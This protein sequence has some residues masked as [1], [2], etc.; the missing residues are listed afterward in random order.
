MSCLGL[1]SLAGVDWLRSGVGNPWFDKKQE[2]EGV[3]IMERFRKY[4]LPVAAAAMLAVVLTLAAPRAVHA[5]TAAL[6][7]VTNTAD[8]PAVTQSI[9]QLTSQNVYLVT[10]AGAVPGGFDSSIQD[11]PNGTLASKPF[12]VPAGQ[13]LVVTTIEVFPAGTNQ[14]TYLLVL[15]DGASGRK[16]LRVPAVYS[17][18]FQYPSGIVFAAGKSVQLFND[19]SSPGVVAISVHG[20][21]TSN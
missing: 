9:N 7:N 3:Q 15:S 8:N 14:G 16:G 10:N 2:R 17:T 19:P 1:F 18:Q 4:S 6:V 13:N 12:V 21:L 11:F 5:V 20:Y